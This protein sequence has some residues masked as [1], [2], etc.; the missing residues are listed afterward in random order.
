MTPGAAAGARKEQPDGVGGGSAAPVLRRGALHVALLGRTLEVGGAERQFVALANGL[1]ARGHRVSALTFYTG[2][3]LRASLGERVDVPELGKKGRYDVFGFQRRLWRVLDQLGPSVIYSWLPVANVLAGLYRLRHRSSRVVWSLRA[4]A[5]DFSAYDWMHGLAHRCEQLCSRLPDRIIANAEAG[6]ADALARGYPAHLLT[7]VPN[8]I[9][10]QRFRPDAEAGRRLRAE[11][12]IAPDAPVVGQVARFDPMKDHPTALAAAARCCATDRRTR[13]LLVGDGDRN[14][15][16]VVRSRVAELGLGQNVLWLGTR[17]D[18]AAVY[19]ACDLLVLSS[20]FG[21]GFPN[22]IGEAMA[23]GVPCVAT[24]SGDTRRIIGDTGEVVPAGDAEALAAAWQRLLAR[25][26]A[27]GEALSSA[28][29]RR[30]VDQFSVES[31]VE[32]TEAVLSEASHS[33]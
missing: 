27:Q 3:G 19:G 21:E 29:R 28:C 10:T 15:M 20:R 31:M 9:D 2:G 30:I 8:G 25:R 23:C 6:R 16:A 13:L 17:T 5:A 11:L 26:A 4:G 22:V 32:A 12:G 24:E 14:Y 1:A 7:V 18:M 33:P